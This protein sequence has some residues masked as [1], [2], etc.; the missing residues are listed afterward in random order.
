[1][2]FKKTFIFKEWNNW[3]HELN[4]SINDFHSLFEIYPNIFLSNNNTFNQIDSYANLKK[5]NI[6]GDKINDRLKKYVFFKLNGFEFDNY[7]LDFCLNEDLLNNEYVLIYDS[8]PDEN[9]EPI[10]VEDTDINALN[11]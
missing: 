1:M 4:V 8:N 7:S 10:P 9:E 5:E 3:D 2:I 11:S 6:S